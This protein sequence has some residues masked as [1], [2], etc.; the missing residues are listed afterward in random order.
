[1]AKRKNPNE[2]LDTI[3]TA[4]SVTFRAKHRSKADPAQWDVVDSFVVE[5]SSVPELLENGDQDPA[6]MKAYGIRAFLCD[7]ASDL[8]AHGVHEY[9][10]A[11]RE[12]YEKTLAVG[13]YK[14]KRESKAR[15]AGLDPLLVQALVD[16][17]GLSPEA[18]IASLKALLPDQL[19]GLKANPKIV[20]AMQAARAAA[21]EAEAVDLGDLL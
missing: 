7:R 6:S 2:S 4:T 19:A 11:I 14:A 8:R 20:Q 15:Q 12:G 3:V 13:V 1:M 5:C 21:Q 16:L 10:K 17:K 9:L 18:A